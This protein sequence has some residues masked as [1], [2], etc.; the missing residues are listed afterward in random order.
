MSYKIEKTRI[1]KLTLPKGY[2]LNTLEIGIP[3][4][5]DENTKLKLNK[6][7]DTILPSREYGC[8]CKRNADGYS[9]ADK[10]SPKKYRTV[11]SF[12][13]APYGNENA[14]PVLVDITKKCYPVIEV[15]PTEIEISLYQNEEN[16]KFI[17][18]NLAQELRNVETI[19]K[20]INIFLEIFR[21]CYV[22]NKDIKITPITIKRYNWDFLPPGEKPSAFIKKQIKSDNSHLKKFDV[23]RLEK[24]ESFKPEQ[25]GQ[26][27]NGFSGYYA[28][29]F[30]KHCFFECAIYGNA[31]YII[32]NDNWEALSQKTKKELTDKNYVVEKIIH[33]EN[34]DNAIT[35]AFTKYE[36]SK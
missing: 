14:D 5:K 17:I 11:S 23:E 1:N 12:Y 26:G 2:S 3:V 32:K 18:A 19:K 25:I 30:N 4:E 31:T 29:I 28:Y 10:E 36:K 24:L 8:V 34:W 9:Y 7:G 33:N 6:V 27:L 15:P 21:V 13:I 22:F 20:A 16:K 35:R